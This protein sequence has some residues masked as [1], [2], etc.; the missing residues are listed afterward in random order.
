MIK[1]IIRRIK[2][3][4]STAC[5]ALPAYLFE[6]NKQPWS[7]VYDLIFISSEKRYAKSISYIRKYFQIENIEGKNILVTLGKIRFVFPDSYLEKPKVFVAVLMLYYDIIYPDTVKHR[8]PLLVHEGPY[9]EA[10]VTID[11]GDIVF[12][13]GANIGMFS[14]FALPKVGTSGKIYAFEPIPNVREI[15]ENSKKYNPGADTV[16]E[17]AP[18]AIGDKDTKTTFDYSLEEI[19]G[20]LLTE[21]DRKIEVNVTSI[22]NFVREHNVQ[23]VDFIKMD[24]EGMERHALKGAEETIKKYK[25]KLA[26][27]IYHLEDDPEVIRGIIEAARSDYQF[28][29]TDFK[30]FAW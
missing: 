23:K 26:I 24:I 4:V 25:P 21:S 10:G 30:I 1:K 29:T 20:T 28:Y 14:F 3:F 2:L 22:D 9:E 13:I 16:I 15:L 12:D 7:L 19:G 17:L 6:K 27:C 5:A 8:I 11:A 18:F